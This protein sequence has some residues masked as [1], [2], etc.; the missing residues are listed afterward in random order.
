MTSNS[1]LAIFVGG[2]SSKY[3]KAFVKEGFTLG[4]LRDINDTPSSQ[5]K[6]GSNQLA[7]ILP[8]NYK[9]A[10]SIQE[11]LKNVYINSDT[12]LICIHEKDFFPSALIAKILKLKQGQSTEVE[13]ARYMTNKYFQRRVFEK[14]FP[15]ITPKFKKIRTFHA[16]YTFARKHKFPVVVK[17]A[18]LYKGE[19]VNI[20]ENLEDLIRKVSYVLDHVQEV[21]QRDKVYRKPQV[22]IEEYIPGKQYSVDSYVDY[23]GNIVHTPICK[24][25]I[26]HDLG[27]DDF[28]TYYS[29]FPSELNLKDEE[30]VFQT[31]SKAIKALKIKAN[32][33]HTEVKITPTGECKVIE[34]NVR[35]GGYRSEMLKESYGID[36]FKNFIRTYLD[37]SVLVSDKFIQYSACPQFWADKQGSFVSASGIAAVKRLESL[38]KFRVLAKPGDEVGTVSAGYGRV[39]Y[40]ILAHKDKDVLEKDLIEIRKILKFNVK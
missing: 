23:D 13:L 19:L 25:V 34:V 24:Q 10:K 40:A 2:I 9:T 36:H 3:V 16:A 38:V 30:L 12:L 7:F 32:T 27:F 21:Y 20:C 6:G 35:P 39:A 17:P 33:T 31:A 1:K 15:E 28:Q 26:S 4:W 22:V 18:N 14:N 29:T 37:E 11:S 5:D 8:V